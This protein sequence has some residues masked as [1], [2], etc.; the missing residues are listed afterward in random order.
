MSKLYRTIFRQRIVNATSQNSVFQY[1]P[2]IRPGSSGDLL[3]RP[4]P[5][6]KNAPKGKVPYSTAKN[7]QYCLRRTVDPIAE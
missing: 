2:D 3:S 7:I 5:K 4:K 1:Q 6:L